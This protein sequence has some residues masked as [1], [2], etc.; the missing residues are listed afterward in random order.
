MLTV[1]DGNGNVFP[2]AIGIVEGENKKTWTWFLSAVR[3]GLGIE[4]GGEGIVILSDRE[5]GIKKAVKRL[6][7]GAAHSYCVFH[8]QKNAKL[9]FKTALDGLLF[10]AAKASR[11]NNFMA[12]LEE[13]K[14]LHKKAGEYVGKIRPEKWARFFF[15]GRR[16]EFF[17]PL[18]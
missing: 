12:A 2:A 15:P 6:F 10:K 3:S 16:S 1:L 11:K 13:M 4:G 14:S 17:L 9:H 7:P 5:K 18:L 8:I